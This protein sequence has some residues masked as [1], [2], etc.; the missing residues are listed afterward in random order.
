MQGITGTVNWTSDDEN[1]E[2]ISLGINGNEV[3]VTA[4][5]IGNAKVTASLDGEEPVTCNIIVKE[6]QTVTINTAVSPTNTGTAEIN[7][8]A[9]YIEGTTVTITPTANTGYKFKEWQDELE[10]KYVYTEENNGQYTGITV[11]QN[12]TLTYTV[13]VSK[14]FTAIFEELPLAF[15]NPDYDNP[16]GTTYYGTQVTTGVTSVNGVPIDDNWKIFFADKDFVYLIYGDYYPGEKE[17]DGVSKNAQTA[18]TG[19]TLGNSLYTVEGD[20]ENK[21]WTLVCYLRNNSN[22]NL[23]YENTQASTPLGSYESW[24]NLANSFNNGNGLAKKVS[25]I[26]GSPD[27]KLWIASWNTRQPDDTTKLKVEW[28]YIRI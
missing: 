12:G 26:Q 13:S 20:S 16:I 28:N 7:E 14:T 23:Q 15:K 4:N 6:L 1:E 3:T 10:N 24:I 11:A 22:V 25:A 19:L 21:Y 2:V 9:P 17:V 27:V 5:G 8:E 18:P